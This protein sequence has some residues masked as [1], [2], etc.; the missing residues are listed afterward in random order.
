MKKILQSVMCLTL[1]SQPVAVSVVNAEE[2]GAPYVLTQSINNIPVEKERCIEL[3]RN[4]TQNNE[5]ESDAIQQ[6]MATIADLNEQIESVTQQ[7]NDSNTKIAEL[8]QLQKQAEEQQAIVV[9]SVY[10]TYRN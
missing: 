2:V 9:E 7:F 3:L 6:L 8:E 5:E 1:L 4:Y 10:T